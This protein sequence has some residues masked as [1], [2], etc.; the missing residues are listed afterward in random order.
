MDNGYKGHDATRPVVGEL[1][2]ANP[3]Q[4]DQE[5]HA[6]QAVDNPVQGGLVKQ[7]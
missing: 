1:G 6:Q 5:S 7:R 3:D 4:N 2:S